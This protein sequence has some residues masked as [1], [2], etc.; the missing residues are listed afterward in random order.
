MYAII[1]F[2]SLSLFTGI[3]FYLTLNFFFLVLSIKH[4][5]ITVNCFQRVPA[6]TAD[7]T[8]G[9]ILSYISSL[10]PFFYGSNSDALPPSLRLICIVLIILGQTFSIVA[11]IDLSDSFGVSAAKRKTVTGGLYR[12]FKHPI[13]LGYA[14]SE[15]GM[16]ICNPEKNAILFIASICLYCA[17]AAREEKLLAPNH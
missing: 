6:Q 8:Q 15:L 12:Y 4:L 14:I 11:I 3:K 9:K 2:F 17:R 10:L 5:I 7:S 16:A 13:Y 1:A